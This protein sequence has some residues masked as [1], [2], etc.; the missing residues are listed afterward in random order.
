GARHAEV[1]SEQPGRV[2]LHLRY[3]RSHFA[4]RQPRQHRDGDLLLRVRAQR[5]RLAHVDPSGVRRD[6]LLRLRR[7]RAADAGGLEGFRRSDRLRLLL[8]LRPSVEPVLQLR[9]RLGDRDVLRLRLPKPAFA[10]LEQAVSAANYYTYD[11]SHRMTNVK[12]LPF[13]GA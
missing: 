4:S 11:T 13:P 10:G 7:S 5:E 3:R 1:A 8:Q 6:D 12:H 9:L 2:V